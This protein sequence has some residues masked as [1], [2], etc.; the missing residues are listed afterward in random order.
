MRI[1]EVELHIGSAQQ[2]RRGKKQSESAL[3]EHAVVL[4]SLFTPS[5]AAA[6]AEAAAPVAAL[7]PNKR[8]QVEQPH[9]TTSSP[10]PAL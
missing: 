3:P 10:C 7:A 9:D 8:R 1:E 6:E 2:P 4:C 5:T